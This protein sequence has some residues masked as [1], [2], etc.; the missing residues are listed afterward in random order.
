VI[1]PPGV[2]L[3]CPLRACPGCGQR[4]ST[5]FDS[6]R[7]ARVAI[8]R[9]IHGWLTLGRPVSGWIKSPTPHSAG[10]VEP[11]SCSTTPAS[12]ARKA[13]T[14]PCVFQRCTSRARPLKRHITHAGQPVSKSHGCDSRVET[15]PCLSSGFAPALPFAHR[16]SGQQRSV[17]YGMSTVPLPPQFKPDRGTTR[18]MAVGVHRTPFEP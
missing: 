17:G 1:G 7:A 11:P 13:G 2:R 10:G 3:P 5:R 4:G 18:S 8:D 6:G 14:S 15:H 16:R 12:H 9:L